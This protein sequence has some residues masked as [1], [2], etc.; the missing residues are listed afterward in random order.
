MDS[1]PYSFESNLKLSFPNDLWDLLPR[2]IEVR[3]EAHTT[4]IQELEAAIVK[5]RRT[6]AQFYA[7]RNVKEVP[8]NARLPQEILCHIF[9]LYAAM[10]REDPSLNERPH[11]WY[12]CALVC[13]YWRKLLLSSPQLF[14]F[15]NL[16][17]VFH[18]ERIVEWLRHSGQMPLVVLLD[19]GSYEYT[20]DHHACQQ[21]IAHILAEL[22]RVRSLELIDVYVLFEVGAITS[23]PPCRQVTELCWTDGEASRFRNAHPPCGNISDKFP[24]LRSLTIT[25]W[26]WNTIWSI[27]FP[28]TLQ[29]L[30]VFPDAHIRKR[31]GLPAFKTLELYWT[32]YCA[33]PF[34]AEYTVA[35]PQVRALT[36]DDDA[37]SILAIL[38][39]FDCLETLSLNVCFLAGFG[40]DD[41]SALKALNRR[42]LAYVMS[43]ANR[44]LSKSPPILSCGL[45]IDRASV[46]FTGSNTL[47]HSGSQS[48]EQPWISVRLPRSCTQARPA[49]EF[50][51]TLSPVLST[52]ESLTLTAAETDYD[53]ERYCVVDYFE[54]IRERFP[55]VRSVRVEVKL[56]PS[57]LEQMLK[58]YAAHADQTLILIPFPAVDTLHILAY[59]VNAFND[60]LIESL[61]CVLEARQRE[62]PLKHL[63][64]CCQNST[65]SDGGDADVEGVN[66]DI[67]RSFVEELEIVHVD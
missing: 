33:E 55:N 53:D 36:I 51:A 61:R 43:R 62:A 13:R 4:S 1:I 12:R 59:T 57:F 49:A 14:T 34:P 63:V 20:L 30:A 38:R 66:L 42:I 18:L 3:V 41:H 5:H 58:P 25:A 45:E 37:I 50:I 21:A 28:P 40:R 35:C 47:Q 29:R 7:V 8:I 54:A 16:R 64:L 6:I 67:L 26:N 27:G 9:S 32:G 22:P 23:W 60:E 11:R 2:E 17:P 56:L 48:M 65:Y 44:D 19:G 46:R 39:Y 15:I 24:N 10:C 52:V 31:R